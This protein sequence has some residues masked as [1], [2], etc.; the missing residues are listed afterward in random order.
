[1][2]RRYCIL[3]MGIYSVYTG[4]IYNEFF[5]VPMAIF[6]DTRFRCFEPRTAFDP[7]SAK[8]RC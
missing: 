2:P 1:M 4:L 8:V 5:S 3:L 6:G 7:A